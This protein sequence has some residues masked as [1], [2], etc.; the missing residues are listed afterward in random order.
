MVRPADPPPTTTTLWLRAGLTGDCATEANVRYAVREC[1]A[2]M[3][4]EA[5]GLVRS[6]LGAMSAV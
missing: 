1:L 3:A 5:A 6:R 4:A 2:A